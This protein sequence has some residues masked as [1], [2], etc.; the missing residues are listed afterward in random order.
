[1]RK[2]VFVDFIRS[3]RLTPPE[4]SGLTKLFITYHM[5]QALHRTNAN[6]V[7][8]ID[9]KEISLQTWDIGVTGE[10]SIEHYS[11]DRN[12]PNGVMLIFGNDL[13]VPLFNVEGRAPKP[14]LG[15]SSNEP[16]G[17]DREDKRPRR[18]DHRL[19]RLD[20]TRHM[21]SVD[22]HIVRSV[23]SKFSGL[24]LE[25][26]Q[27]WWHEQQP[28]REV[29]RFSVGQVVYL[30]GEK[31]LL[32]AAWEVRAT[33][34]AGDRDITGCHLLSGAVEPMFSS[35]CGTEQE[36]LKSRESKQRVETIPTDEE[37]EFINVA[38][39]F[40]ERNFRQKESR[41]AR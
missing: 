21:D 24:L 19:E 31:D 23:Y 16:S 40:I 20:V 5:T 14:P 37:M 2:E 9:G 1:M 35:N 12:A 4:L 33:G 39:D 26:L 38:R 41:D 29:K 10:V 8:K 22:I 36:W 30:F 3:F 6:P 13:R 32:N 15:G 18:E 17:D 11:D 7:L 27:A 34:Q 25:L 28:M